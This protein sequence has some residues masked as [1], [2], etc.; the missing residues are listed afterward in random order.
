MRDIRLLV[1]EDDA[2][3]GH[4]I[5]E[6]CQLRGNIE[7]HLA[8]TGQA[9]LQLL[10]K[11]AFDYMLLDLSLPDISGFDFYKSAIESSPQLK[12]R[13]LLMSGHLPKGEIEEFLAENDIRFLQKPFSLELFLEVL[14]TLTA[15]DSQSVTST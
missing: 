1:L 7:T 4:L 3:I 10:E 13:C 2:N 15:S 9:G 14:D 11:E 5:A 6:V 12:N 8:V